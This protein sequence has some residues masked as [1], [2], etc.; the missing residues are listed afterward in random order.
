MLLSVSISNSDYQKWFASE[1]DPTIEKHQEVLS[2][3]HMQPGR[4]AMWWMRAAG[5]CN[6][7]H[8][9]LH[10]FWGTSNGT[11]S[12]AVWMKGSDPDFEEQ[13]KMK[14]NLAS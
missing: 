2:S 14:I 12:T 5:S 1:S 6:E 10:S 9:W 4:S 13:G 8:P 3:K 11:G 7:L